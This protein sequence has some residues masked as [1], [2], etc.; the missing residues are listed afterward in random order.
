METGPRRAT[1]GHHSLGQLALSLAT[2]PPAAAAPCIYA[3]FVKA[4]CMHRCTVQRTHDATCTI[5]SLFLFELMW[6]GRELFARF[7][8]SDSCMVGPDPR[9]C[10]GSMSFLPSSRP[11]PTT[12]IGSRSTP[13]WI[14]LHV[15]LVAVFPSYSLPSKKTNENLASRK[16]NNLRL[17]QILYSLYPFARRIINIL[18]LFLY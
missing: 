1:A 7:K 8:G 12:I 16:L 14:P 18:F 4:A 17:N 3:P 9:L 2:T 11:W 15:F 5:C 6:P 13:V 10:A